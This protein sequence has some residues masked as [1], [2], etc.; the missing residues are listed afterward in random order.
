LAIKNQYSPPKAEFMPAVHY[1]SMNV[2]LITVSDINYVEC[3]L[4]EET[5]ENGAGEGN[6]SIE[7]SQPLTIC[8]LKDDE[9][10]WLQLWLHIE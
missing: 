7:D 3:E 2:C 5:F 8:F 6:R 1:E 9:S 10:L 4:E